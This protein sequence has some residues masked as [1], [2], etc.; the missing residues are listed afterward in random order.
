MIFPI[1]C[2]YT[3][4]SCRHL[5]KL[6]L[7]FERCFGASSFVADLCSI[8]LIYVGVLIGFC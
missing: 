4:T 6:M 8:G 5:L 2:A 3:P 1:L 7:T